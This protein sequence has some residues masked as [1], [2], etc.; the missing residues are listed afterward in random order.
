MHSCTTALLYHFKN[1]HP[2]SP[3]P[4]Y[5]PTLRPS[6]VNYLAHLY[7]S[8]NQTERMIGNFIADHVKGKM[9]DRFPEK[10]REGILLHRM[11]DQFT[12]SHPVVEE[13][14]IR[15][16]PLFHKYSPVI[17]DV[18]YDHF[19]ARDW[20]TYHHQPLDEF[21][22]EVYSLMQ[23]HNAILPERTKGMLE[24]MQRQN[25][26]LNYRLTE[27]I[28]RALSGMSRRTTFESGMEK[29]TGF[30][31]THYESFEKEFAEFFNDMRKFVATVQTTG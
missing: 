8:G 26:L 5:P 17:V 28:H 24:Y 13:S 11:I 25:W 18:F 12:D 22:N 29:A 31:E 27:G 23:R 20:D 9:I 4:C 30:L 6:S 1:C 2:A 10:V 3:L 7:L 21:S 15:L 14:K 19:L 16:R